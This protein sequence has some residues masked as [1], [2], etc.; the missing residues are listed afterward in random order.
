MKDNDPIIESFFN[1]LTETD[2]DLA[3]EILMNYNKEKTEMQNKIE[4]LNEK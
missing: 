3:T 4:L 2:P 1:L